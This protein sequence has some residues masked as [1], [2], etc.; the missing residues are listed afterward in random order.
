MRVILNEQGYVHEYAL[1]GEFGTPSLVVDEPEDIVDFENNYGSYYIA[2]G[3]LVKNHDKQVELEDERLLHDL[4]L[5]REKA[6]FP[7]VN[8]GYLWYSKLT[9]EQ[10]SELADWYQAWLDVTDTKIVPEAPTW[11]KI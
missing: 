1:V 4:R 7:Y 9:D 3:V 2:N 6:C 5:Q 8:R 11:L 10:K